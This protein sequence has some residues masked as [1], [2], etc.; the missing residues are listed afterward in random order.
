MAPNL[1]PLTDLLGT[2]EAT[3]KKVLASWGP[4]MFDAL[5]NLDGKRFGRMGRVQQP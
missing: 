1:K 2:D 4:G 3:V 5:L